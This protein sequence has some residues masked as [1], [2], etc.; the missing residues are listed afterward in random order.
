MT[1]APTTREQARAMLAEL[2]TLGGILSDLRELHDGIGRVSEHSSSSTV[3]ALSLLPFVATNSTALGFYSD[4]ID[5]NGA[6]IRELV[7][8]QARALRMLATVGKRLD[9]LSGATA[10]LRVVPAEGGGDV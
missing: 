10:A 1:A 8:V 4:V 2:E 6:G 7:D 9:A 3:A 5:A